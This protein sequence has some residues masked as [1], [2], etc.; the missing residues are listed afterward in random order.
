MRYASTT[1]ALALLLAVT[2]TLAAP[3]PELIPS[4]TRTGET[5]GPVHHE[6]KHHHH[7]RVSLAKWVH[8]HLHYPQHWP[9]HPHH[10]TQSHHHHHHHHHVAGNNEQPKKSGSMLLFWLHSHFAPHTSKLRTHRGKPISDINRSQR[11]LSSSFD[12][13]PPSDED[14]VEAR[15]LKTQSTPDS[16]GEGSH[17]LQY[18]PKDLHKAGRELRKTG[19]IAE[20][21]E[22]NDDVVKKMHLH[23]GMAAAKLGHMGERNGRREID[24]LD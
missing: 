22:V 10:E 15:G 4:L 23:I 3:V 2:S 6:H 14:A 9:F 20:M 5:N 17:E 8:D 11:V 18:Q 16:E 24:D 1:A 21:G 12:E 13:K 7:H 19:K